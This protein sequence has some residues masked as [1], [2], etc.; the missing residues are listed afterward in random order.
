[1]LPKNKSQLI[2]KL[3]SF[4]LPEK[5][6]DEQPLREDIPFIPDTLAAFFLRPPKVTFLI[7]RGALIFAILAIIWAS[8]SHLDE[9]T[10][11]EGKV[12]PSGRIQIIQNLEGGI[13][14]KLPVHV[15]EMVKKGQVVLKLDE[16]RF[17][18]SAS[19]SKIKK[20][21][22]RAKLARLTAESSGDPF[23]IDEEFAKENPAIAEEEKMLFTK[24]KAEL[25][26]TLSVLQQQY[27]SVRSH[28]T[29]LNRS[30]Q[31]SKSELNLTRPLAKRGVISEVEFMRLQRQVN[32]LRGELESARLGMPEAKSKLDG[33]LAKFRAEAASELGLVKAE[34][35]SMSA[36]GLAVDD[37]L[38][39]TT[40]R[41]PVNG[42]VKAI[43]ANTVG[44]VIQPG[45]DV[46]EIV[47][48][49]DRLLVEVKVRPADIGFLRVGQ[50][51]T[52][53]ISAYDYSIY[54][55][56]DAEVKNITADS[57]TDDRGNSF[58]L[59][60][61]QTEKNGFGV[62][63][64]SLTIIPGMLATASIRTGRKSV[65]SYILK[66]LFKAKQKA[67]TER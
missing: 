11:G 55:G 25:D 21:A 14:S 31:L 17:A 23:T 64:K 38:A 7:L 18:S 37:R 36:T 8:L 51:A 43:N 59:V 53:K 42:I 19:E 5:R 47:P 34:Y 1:M 15:G 67:L 2:E 20:Q 60:Q 49:E 24:R 62:D 46:M 35:A 4:I 3:K 45:V 40:L 22:L 57:I 16:T 61:V 28:V 65:L 54:G 9:I 63:E 66:P 12:I 56:L 39:R 6:M 52:V 26:A 44:G 13:V 32:D 50:P 41:S 29:H 27:D 33:A 58:Y 10:N 30:Y 48:I